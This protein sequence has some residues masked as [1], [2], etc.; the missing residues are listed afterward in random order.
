MADLE[1]MLNDAKQDILAKPLDVAAQVAALANKKLE[2]WTEAKGHNQDYLGDKR[3]LRV[4]AQ[5]QDLTRKYK[6]GDGSEVTFWEYHEAQRAAQKGWNE[7]YDG[8]MVYVLCENDIEMQQAQQAVKANTV[9]GIIVGVPKT[10]LPIKDTVVNLLAIQAFMATDAYDKL[11]FQEKALAE[12][13]LGK[14][15][16]KTGRIGDFLRARERY[17]DAKGL[18]WYRDD[19]K[20]LLADPN[21]EYEPADLLMTRLFDEAQY[22]HP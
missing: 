13:M 12:D 14:E 11:E 16:Q 22:G 9:P 6:L 18:H 15:A 20:T 19:G 4:F 21:N 5:P 17:L 8:V 2:P 3:L 1:A 10:P 7:R